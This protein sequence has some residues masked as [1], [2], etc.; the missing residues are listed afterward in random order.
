MAVTLN[1]DWQNIAH[2]QVSVGA[3][4]ITFWLDCKLNRQEGNDSYVDTRLL[5]SVTNSAAGSGYGFWI[6][7]ST[8]N[9]GTGVWT[10]VDGETCV[11]G[12]EKITHNDDGTKS[13]VIITGAYNNYL[14]FDINFSGDITLPRIPKAPY[15]SSISI[16]TVTYN[17]AAAIFTVTDNG[18][19]TVTSTSLSLYSDSGLTQLVETKSGTSA[20]FTGL[21]PNRHYWVVGRASNSVGTRSTGQYQIDTE[22]SVVRV[23][24]NGQWKESVPYVRVSGQWKEVTPNIRSNGQWKE[25]I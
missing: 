13:A 15:L 20:T 11:S 4:T 8:G 18:G 7:G 10:Y 24:I 22:G 12:Q 21:G 25:G 2:Y 5:T 16:G 1:Y 14:G 3:A 9:F 17:S 19:A 23:R 6:S